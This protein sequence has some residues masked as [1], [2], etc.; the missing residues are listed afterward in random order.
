MIFAG[1][2]IELEIIMSGKISQ[3]QTDHFSLNRQDLNLYMYSS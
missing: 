3:S 1:K 2:W